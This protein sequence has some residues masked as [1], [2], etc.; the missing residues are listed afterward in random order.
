MSTRPHHDG[1]DQPPA[2]PALDE[3]LHEPIPAM[4]MTPVPVTVEGP[5]PV[6][7]Q[8]N[9]SGAA[10]TAELTTTM[11]HILGRQPGRSR[12][13]M[14][15]DTDWRYSATQSGAG[16]PWYAKVPLVITHADPVFASVPTST[17]TLTVITESNGA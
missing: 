16:V 8:P 5:V 10:F 6:V 14:I 13:T 11:V 3:Q 9:R 4:P 2:W 7:S 1:I 17:G 15:C 12:V